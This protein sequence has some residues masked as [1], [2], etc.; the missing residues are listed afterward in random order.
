[1]TLQRIV[2]TILFSAFC[3]AAG[4][5]SAFAKPAGKAK[6]VIGKVILQTEQGKSI[7]LKRGK[8]VS[9]GDKI[10]TNNRSQ[11]QLIMIDGT[12]ISIRPSTQFRIEEFVATG[13]IK[14][15]KTHYELLSGG[16]RSVTGSIGKKNKASF[17]LKTP[18][19]TMGI[20]GT[21]FVGSY[22]K[23]NCP[24]NVKPGLY[25][26]VVSGG[27]S[28]KNEQGTMNISPK[29]NGY[30]QS[31]KAKPQTIKS[32]PANF[33]SPKSSNPS[34]ASKGAKNK[35]YPSPEAEFVQ[36]ATFVAPDLKKEIINEAV[37]AGVSVTEIIN[38][39]VDGGLQKDTIVN[40]V[41][42]AGK[43]NGKETS[44]L[45]ESI[46]DSNLDQKN[47]IENLMLENK[48][49]AADI[50]TSAIAGNTENSEQLKEI[51]RSVGVSQEEVQS[52]EALG[53]MLAVP[54]EIKEIVKESNSNN[55]SSS[56]ESIPQQN[57]RAR[58]LT[59]S[60]DSQDAASPF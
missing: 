23:R 55:N 59:P 19:A 51:A 6:M 36:I 13:D 7:R 26:D 10:I 54:D 27:V 57:I 33:L 46:I 40:D 8:P 25:V 5:H 38:G 14:K 52:A 60:T 43:R 58:E 39:A 16:F 21:D 29:K 22:C 47:V 48:D 30:V 1:M 35:G 12:N 49:E 3:F 37:S 20:R 50:L 31:S 45:I 18:V 4:A 44:E 34:A 9:A 53:S 56:Q 24:P 28:M 32:L 11:V 42:D 17:K 41:M 2:F 15:D